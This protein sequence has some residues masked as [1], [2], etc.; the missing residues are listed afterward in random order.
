MTARMPNPA[1]VAGPEVIPALLG[2]AGAVKNT[3]VPEATINLIYLRASQINGSS[4]NVHKHAA[5]LKAAGESDERISTVAAWRE[6]PFF[7]P[8]ERAALA[9]AE[10]ATR[11]SDRQGDAVS[12]EVWAEAAKY[13]SDQQLA[14]ILLA[15]G[16]SNLWHRLIPTTRQAAGPVAG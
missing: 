11:L 13:F 12:D 7:T 14:G 9:L 2:V 8:E 6:T 4:W 10:A 16:L 3:G 5:D 15:T 1:I